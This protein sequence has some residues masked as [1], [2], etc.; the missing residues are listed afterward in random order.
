VCV[1]EREREREAEVRWSVRNNDSVVTVF[2]LHFARKK[3]PL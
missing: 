2:I 3:L 1:C